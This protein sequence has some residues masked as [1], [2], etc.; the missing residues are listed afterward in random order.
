MRDR[1]VRV[2]LIVLG[3]G[4]VAI[5]TWAAFAPRSFYDDFPGFGR[6]WVRVDG[7]YNEHLVRDF[8]AL[9]LALAVVTIA[10]AIVLARPLVIAVAI[11]WLAWG[12]PHL[13][14]H[15][16][17]LDVFDTSDQV[18]NVVLLAV[19]PVL[20]LA[21]LVLELRKPAEEA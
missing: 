1:V 20:A 2:I 12:V 9:S 15:A 18:L 10:A 6:H 16:R 19:L 13:V 7:P 17:H 8:G 3:V 14:Y 4:N 21:V 11:A 5:G